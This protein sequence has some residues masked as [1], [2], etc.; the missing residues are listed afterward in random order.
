[1][2]VRDMELK[3]GDFFDIEQPCSFDYVSSELSNDRIEL[4][5]VYVL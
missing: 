2:K 3:P 1:M 4:K 5:G